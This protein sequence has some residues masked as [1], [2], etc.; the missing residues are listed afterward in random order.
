[1][2]FGQDNGDQCGRIFCCKR[3]ERKRNGFAACSECLQRSLYRRFSNV[4]TSEVEALAWEAAH[5]VA[6]IS[7]E[8]EYETSHKMVQRV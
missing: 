4:W 7:R 5:L 2:Y 6:I 8:L 3:Q 1:M